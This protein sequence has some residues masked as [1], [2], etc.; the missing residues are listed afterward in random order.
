M[1]VTKSR[2]ARVS[3]KH[4]KNRQHKIDWPQF[5]RSALPP[6]ADNAAED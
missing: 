4:N 1:R 5:W 2:S 6:E 3:E